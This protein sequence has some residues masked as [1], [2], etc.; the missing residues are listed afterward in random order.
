[1]RSEGTIAVNAGAVE[2][3]YVINYPLLKQGS[4]TSILSELQTLRSSFPSVLIKLI[5][6]TSQ[7]NFLDIVAGSLLAA[8]AGL[9]F[10]KTSTG[11]MGAGAKIDDVRLMRYVV[12]REANGMGVKAS[13]GIRSAADAVK[14]LRAGATRL[15]L[16]GSVAIME[17]GQDNNLQASGPSSE[18]YYD[19]SGT[20]FVSEGS[21]LR[22]RCLCPTRPEV[23][24]NK[25]ASARSLISRKPCLPR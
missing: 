2:L 23:S 15:G 16:S 24:Q 17:E 22:P 5:L 25:E 11:F 13:G 9:D 6:E 12:S 18:S 4:Y 8:A 3:D 7:L 14:M 10:V 20:Q 19:V 1:M 21:E